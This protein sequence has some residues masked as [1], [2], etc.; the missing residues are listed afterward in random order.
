MSMKD[1][2]IFIGFICILI[3][4][5]PYFILGEDAYITIHDFLDQNV[6]IMADL[7]NNGLLMSLNGIVPNMEGLDRGLFPYFTPF[8]VKM[9]CYALLPI[10]WAIVVYTLIYKIIAFLGMYLLLDKYVFYEKNKLISLLLSLGFAFVPFYMELALS[11]AGFP[12]ALYAFLNLYYNKNRN[13]SYIAIAFYTFN[14]LLAY[15]GFF[16][17]VIL[18]CCM[19]YDYNQTKKFSKNIIL[20]II[21]MCAVYLLANWGT[22]YSLFFSESFVSHR[23]EWVHSTSFWDDIREFGKILF[24][25][26]QHAGNI[27]AVPVL[28][29]FII[30]LIK[31]SKKYTLLRRMA[32]LY[33]LIVFG[34]FVGIMLKHSPVQLFVTIQ[35][36]R[37]Y[38]FYPSI[39]MMILAAICYV[40]IMEKHV[41]WAV[42][43]AVYGLVCGLKNDNEY[44]NNIRLLAHCQIKQP[45]FRQFYDTKLFKQICSDLEI[46]SDY[47]TKVVSIGLYPSVAEFN[48]FYTI[49][50]YRVNY[51]VEFKHQFR[52]VIAG[53]LGK[54]ESLRH[55]YDDWGSRCYIFS[56]ELKEQGNQYLCSKNDNLV[57]EHFDIDIKALKDL[58]C[59]YVLASVDIKNFKELNL[60]YINSYTTDKSYWN[61]RVYKIL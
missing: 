47:Q 23:S 24:W 35:F 18:F 42:V 57:V 58:G 10:Y 22:I 52:K 8:D 4:M 43:L 9:V 19:I 11:G 26:Q 5:L 17:L 60:E 51:P 36:D 29:L 48:G 20:G 54:N 16:L 39:V 27:I 40:T 14:S 53:E 37:F 3:F 56:A 49:D 50:S 28:L 12:L 31:Y 21:L 46:K 38:F 45:T 33:G 61:I 1:K 15:G 59:Q 44:K 34:I 55:Y 2:Y 7:K 30:M 32:L 6:V 41:K 25:S 13:W